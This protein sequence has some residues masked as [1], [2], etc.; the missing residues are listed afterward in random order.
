MC[1]S[2]LSDPLFFYTPTSVD[3][4]P[5]HNESKMVYPLKK[6]KG[7]MVYVVFYKLKQNWIV[8]SPRNFRTHL[9]LVSILE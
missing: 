4:G 5:V 6:T 3:R 2:A 1:F 8:I 7:R 9:D